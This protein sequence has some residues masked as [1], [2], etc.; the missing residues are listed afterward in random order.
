MIGAGI[1]TTQTQTLLLSILIQNRPCALVVEPDAF[2][3][4]H[5]D[6][7][8]VTM[9]AIKYLR[10]GGLVGVGFDRTESFLLTVSHSGRGVFSTSNWE[11]VARDYSLAYPQDGIAIGI[12]PIEGE[13]IAV[14]QLDSS[15]PAECTS[16]SGRFKLQCESSGIEVHARESRTPCSVSRSATCCCRGDSIWWGAFRR[17]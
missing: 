10:L 7:A 12:G 14:V 11:R 5:A 16:Q 4:P 13:R 17:Q 6:D 8:A 3:P 9:K 15:A 1:T 2:P